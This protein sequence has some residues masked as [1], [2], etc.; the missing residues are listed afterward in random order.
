[1]M[2]GKEIDLSQLKEAVTKT[3]LVHSSK[4]PARHRFL[5]FFKCKLGKHEWRACSMYLN[6]DER[7]HDGPQLVW[8]IECGW[9]RHPYDGDLYLKLHEMMPKTFPK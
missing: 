5:H 1:M 4:L 7:S 8:T 9:C 2:P 6:I 3:R